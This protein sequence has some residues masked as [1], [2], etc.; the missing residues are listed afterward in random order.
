MET[1]NGMSGGE[2]SFSE[3]S[4]PVEVPHFS[5]LRRIPIGRC[6]EDTVLGHE[7]EDRFNHLLLVPLDRMMVRTMLTSVHDFKMGRVHAESLAAP[8][9]NDVTIAIY[10]V[11]HETQAVRRD[12]LAS[13]VAAVVNYHLAVPS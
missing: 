13:S 7:L 9:M 5:C 4:F 12:F 3:A 6:W 2:C 8:V 1:L 10:S 11:K